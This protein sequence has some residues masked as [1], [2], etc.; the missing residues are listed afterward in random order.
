MKIILI[1]ILLFSLCVGNVF[2]EDI[3]GK[4][5]C[6]LNDHSDGLFDVTLVLKNNP[7]ASFPK[8]SYMSYDFTFEFTALG[9]IHTYE[10][11]ASAHGNN[12]AMYF[13]STG[14]HKDPSDK[15]VG[16]AS[17]S[18]IKDTITFSKFYYEPAYQG[19]V[20]YG[21]EECVKSS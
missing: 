14:D 9:A 10:G 13:E 7:Q 17:V 19:K 21:F 6:H 2:A 11:F 12:M 5:N 18:T 15:G 8:Q 20:N 1:F 16:I 4:Y 3:S